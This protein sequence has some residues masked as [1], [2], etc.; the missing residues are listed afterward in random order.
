MTIKRRKRQVF[1][2]KQDLRE[3]RKKGFWFAVGVASLTE[4]PKSHSC[5]KK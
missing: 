4:E 3:D 2:Q 1:P 5:Y